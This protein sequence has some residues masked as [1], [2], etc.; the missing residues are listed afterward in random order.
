MTGKELIDYLQDRAGEYH[1]GTIQYD[2]HDFDILHTRDDVRETYLRS[3]VDRILKRIRPESSTEEERSFSFG[4]LNATVRLFDEVII[5]HFPQAKDRGII[6][7]LE[8][9]TASNL[10]TFIEE[11]TKRIKG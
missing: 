7:S 10:S 5:I 9:E 11:C 2:R 8:P 1:R 4:E 3:R 6:V